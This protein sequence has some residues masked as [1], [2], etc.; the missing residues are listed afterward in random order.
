[1]L[2]NST[3][4]RVFAA[5]VA[6]MI[7]AVIA[8]NSLQDE[9][10]HLGM[11]AYLAR[12]PGI[13]WPAFFLFAFGFPAGLGISVMGLLAIARESRLRLSG[14]GL[15]LIGTTLIPA[16]VPRMFGSHASPAFF[17]GGGYAIMAMVMTAFWFW[18]VYSATLPTHRRLAAHLQGAGYVC[19]AL[20][21][22]NL[23]G[24]GGMPSFAL[25]PDKMQ[26]VGSREFAVGQ[27]KAVLSLMLLG[28]ILTAAGFHQATRH[29]R[30]DG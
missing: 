10:A 1:M 17:G 25:D 16:L 26:A 18:G 29:A 6:V 20:A 30:K 5:G 27:M 4:I 12:H 28:W 19:F 2:P 23:C 15:F 14:F 21:A 3:A 22:W 8:G 13:G 7:A 24:V 11:D 9:V